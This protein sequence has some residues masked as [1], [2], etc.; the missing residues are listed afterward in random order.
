MPEYKV[1]NAT[2]LDADLLSLADSIRAKSGATGPLAFPDEMKS[3]VEGITAEDLSGVLDEQESKLNALLE[4]LD[5][6]AAGGGAVSS[7]VEI[8][9]LTREITEYSNPTLEKLG[10]YAF[11]GTKITS[12]NL[13]ALTTIAGYAFYECTTLTTVNFPLLTEIPY[14]G[15]RAFKGLVQADLPAVTKIGSNGFYQCTAL[16]TL[17]LRSSSLCA[18]VTG[19][20]LTGSKIE[21]GTGYVYVPAAL[22][23]SYKAASNWSNYADQIR[24]IEDYPEITGG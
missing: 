18:L 12:L 4:S 16:E 21:S 14:N 8:S 6:K 7:D 11:S 9:L 15:F 17:I 19:T 5:R 20:V 1:V 22:V 13:P 23:E 3:A 10:A 24:A 2:Q